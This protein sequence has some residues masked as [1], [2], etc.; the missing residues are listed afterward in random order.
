MGRTAPGLAGWSLE[1]EMS[2]RTASGFAV[3]T[4]GLIPGA[5]TGVASPEFLDTSGWLQN[6]GQVGPELSLQGNGASL[7]CSCGQA[8]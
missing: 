4:K 8:W 3:L 1:L 5:W 7:V 2:H 6:G